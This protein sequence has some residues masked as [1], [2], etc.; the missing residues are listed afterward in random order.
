MGDPKQ[1]LPRFDRFGRERY[2]LMHKKPVGPKT[3]EGLFSLYEQLSHIQ[4]PREMYMAGWAALEASM[5]GTEFAATDRVWL[6]D[7]AED[8][9]QYALELQQERAANKAWYKN[10]TPDTTSEYRIA[11][12]LSTVPIFRELPY[13]KPSKQ[14]MKD[15]FTRQLEIATLNN[16]DMLVAKAHQARHRYEGMFDY[17]GREANHRGLAYEQLSRLGVNRL[18]STRLFATSSLARADSGMYYPDQTHDNQCFYLDGGEITATVPLEVKSRLRNRY[19]FRYQNAGLV[20]GEGLTHDGHYTIDGMLRRLKREAEG[21]ADLQDIEILT[22]LTDDVI[23][24]IR[25]YR[26]P[27]RAGI[28]CHDRRKCE[29]GRTAVA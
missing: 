22:T 18:L 26:R 14:T 17:S 11:D 7:T 2:M 23:H 8:A 4:T 15:V 21:S 20:G 1:T 10:T 25:H 3:A 5:V 29:L 6:V 24:S 28:H 16:Q 13:G 9:W 12:A 19:F 27:E